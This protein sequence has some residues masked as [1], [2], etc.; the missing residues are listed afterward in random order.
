MNKKD[1]HASKKAISS[2]SVNIK[3]IIVSNRVKHNDDNYQYF[4]SY[5]DDDGIIRPLCV[6]SP[7][8]SGYVKYFDNGGKNMPFKIESEDVYL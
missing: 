8:M 3:N 7:Q 1:F 5:S 2:N 4:I 6:I